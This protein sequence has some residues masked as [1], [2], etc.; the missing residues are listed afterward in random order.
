MRPGLCWAQSFGQFCT[1]TGYEKGRERSG[2]RNKSE[3]VTCRSNRRVK[4]YFDDVCE[5]MFFGCTVIRTLYRIDFW[6][7][8]INV[9]KCYLMFQELFCIYRE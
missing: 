9:E 1:N 7:Y 8:G 4:T 6:N 2:E 5:T 3:C